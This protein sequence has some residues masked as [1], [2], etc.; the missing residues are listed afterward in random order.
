[1]ATCNNTTTLTLTLSKTEADFLAAVLGKCVYWSE[2]AG[3]IGS[4]IYDVLMAADANDDAFEASYK[5]TDDL[6]SIRKIDE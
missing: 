2:G 6:F 4:D 5:E 1:M 3:D